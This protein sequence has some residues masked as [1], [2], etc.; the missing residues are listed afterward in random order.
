MPAILITRTTILYA[1]IY[2]FIY[3]QQTL[4]QSS[5]GDIVSIMLQIYIKARSKYQPVLAAFMRLYKYLF[6]HLL[7]NMFK[8]TIKKVIPNV[9]I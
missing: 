5:T 8:F 2:I 9:K 3:T 7:K 6:C 4:C 1:V